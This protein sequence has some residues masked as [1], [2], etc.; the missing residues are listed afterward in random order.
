MVKSKPGRDGNAL[1]LVPARGHER[2]G[3]SDA[4]VRNV[5]EHPIDKLLDRDTIEGY[6]HRAA[7]QLLRDWELSQISAA[8]AAPLEPSVDGGRSGDLSATQ[9]DALSRVNDAMAELGRANRMIV[10]TLVVGRA[11]LDDLGARMRAWGYNWPRKR[12]AAPRV[13]E[14]LHELALHYGLATKARSRHP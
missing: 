8:R 10:T 5:R 4:V 6:H 3:K 1:E 9:A 7:E 11:N 2:Y 13:C 14:A 12:Y